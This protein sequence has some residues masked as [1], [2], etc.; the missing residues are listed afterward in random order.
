MNYKQGYKIQ[1]TYFI[2]TVRCCLITYYVTY[3]T[4]KLKLYPTWHDC[5]LPRHYRIKTARGWKIN[6]KGVN[7]YCSMYSDIFAT[8]RKVVES[9]PDGI[10]GIFHRHNPF[11]RT[12]AL[13]LT[14]PP[15]RNEYQ[16]Y[17]LG[18]KAAGA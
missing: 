18:V 3:K 11:G 14:Q 8:N 5:Y 9:I 10:I 4:E 2:V 1:N 7:N 12:M 16:E 6:K 17:F 15:N 13:W